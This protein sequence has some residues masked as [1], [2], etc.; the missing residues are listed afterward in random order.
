MPLLAKKTS[1]TCLRLRVTGDH[2]QQEIALHKKESDGV[3]KYQELKEE[4]KA[5]ADIASSVPEGF[6]DKCFELLLTNLIDT[7]AKP[8]GN[9]KPPTSEKETTQELSPRKSPTGEGASPIPM[10]AQVRVVM[11]RGGV[12]QAELE[13]ILF[14]EGEEVHF[15]KEPHGVP[16]AQG[17]IE[18]ALLLAL[19][20]AIENDSLSAD[21]EA[22]RSVCQEKGFYDRGNFA[23]I[24]KR[25]NNTGLFKEP[26][27]PQGSP[28]PLT[29]EGQDALAKLIKRLAAQS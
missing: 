22:V 21:P 23:T 1:Q 6:R 3:M 24:F 25:S 12:T 11:R 14:Y 9:A 17:Q 28:Q 5:I 10:K 7:T 2:S 8:S 16:N 18:W 13:S 20:N 19:K 15:V 26:L 27:E 29:I 4:I